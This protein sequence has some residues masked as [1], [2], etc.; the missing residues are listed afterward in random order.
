MPQATT[1]PGQKQKLL[2][3]SLGVYP[4]QKVH[5]DYYQAQNRY[6]IV[7][8]RVLEFMNKHSKRNSNASLIL[9]FLKNAEPQ[10]GPHLASLLPKK[11]A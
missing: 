4:H 8:I 3:G 5:I 11:M 10:S 2:D 6:T 1:P 7:C 9:E